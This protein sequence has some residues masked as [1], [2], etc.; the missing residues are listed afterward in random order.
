LSSVVTVSGSPELALALGSTTRYAQYLSGSGTSTLWFRYIVQPGDSSPAMDYTGTNA[1]LLNG[2]TI[3]DPSGNPITPVLPAPG[4]TESLAWHEGLT[5]DTTVPVVSSIDR[6]DPATVNADQ[7]QFA[8]TFSKP[9]YN[10]TAGD[11]ALAGS[12]VTGTISSVAGGGTSYVVTVEISG[13]GTLGLDLVN[14]DTIVDAGGNPLGGPGAGN[15]NFTGEVFNVVDSPITLSMSIVKIAPTADVAFSGT[16]ASFTDS[17]PGTAG[18]Y[19]AT[20]YWGDGSTSVVTSTATAAGQIVANG[21]VFDVNA[22]HTYPGYA[23]NDTFSVE[24]DSDAGPGVELSTNIAV[25]DAPLIGGT[26]TP[27][28]AVDGTPTGNV[29]L[30]QFSGSWVFYAADWHVESC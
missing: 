3:L 13:T 8:V 26:L 19:S 12:G 21:G 16:V 1:V 30:Y 25:A 17:Y 18:D 15:G 14:D 6:M 11:F 20:I 28:V 2:G 27:P 5:I 24:I 7:V 22:S 10:V 29:L 23:A 4:L 9:V